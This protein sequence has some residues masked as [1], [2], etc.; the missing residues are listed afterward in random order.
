[1]AVAFDDLPA[2]GGPEGG[3][4]DGHDLCQAAAY[5][6]VVPV[7]EHGEVCQF[8]F[9][10]EPARLGDLSLDLFAVAHDDPAVRLRTAGARRE[11]ETYARRKSL[12]KV[13]GSP[14]HAGDVALDMSLIGAAGAAEVCRHLMHGEKTVCGKCR[15]EAR[16]GV[17]VA[18]DYAVALR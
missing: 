17:A 14:V 9:R 1:M 2:V 7:D 13:A 11:R 5:L 18:D 16:R 4:I 8:F 10:R 6:D 3:N 12:P 15:V